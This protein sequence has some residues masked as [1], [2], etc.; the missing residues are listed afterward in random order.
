M[1]KVNAL[2]Y[3]PEYRIVNAL[4]HIPEYRISRCVHDALLDLS[5]EFFVSAKTIPNSA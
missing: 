3:I 4:S 1:E 2:S 5:G